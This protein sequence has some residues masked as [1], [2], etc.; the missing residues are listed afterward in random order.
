MMWRCVP[1]WH[2][3]LVPWKRHLSDLLCRTG[4]LLSHERQAEGVA[5]YTVINWGRTGAIL[6]TWELLE[7]VWPLGCP[8]MA[9]YQ[10]APVFSV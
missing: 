4:W 3:H 9:R 7:L 5:W 10:Q 2:Q 1:T 8:R 6:D